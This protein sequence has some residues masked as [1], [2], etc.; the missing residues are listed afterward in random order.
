MKNNGLLSVIARCACTLAMFMTSCAKKVYIPAQDTTVSTP[1]TPKLPNGEVELITFCI[2]D[3][4]DKPGEYMAGLG[5]A[6][7]RPDRA[8]A[9]TD[10]NRVAIAD[11]ASRYVGMIKNAIEDYSKDTNVPAGKKMYESSPGRRC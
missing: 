11:I 4:Y 6:E 8:R 3:A 2:D 1:T 5:I 10:A 9:I 7:D